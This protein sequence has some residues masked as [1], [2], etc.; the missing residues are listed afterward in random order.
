MVPVHLSIGLPVQ[1]LY[2]C[3]S[4]GWG[5]VYFQAEKGVS[6]SYPPK[7]HRLP[8]CVCGMGDPQVRCLG[9]G[10]IFYIKERTM[11]AHSYL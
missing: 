9:T 1:V 4:I 5:I 10:Y 6:D 11:L 7:V 3:L 8:L 2:R